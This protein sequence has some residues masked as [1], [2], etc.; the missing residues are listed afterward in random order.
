M[1]GWGYKHKPLHSIWFPLSR[2]SENHILIP[3]GI[4]PVHLRRHPDHSRPSISRLIHRPPPPPPNNLP[5]SFSSPSRQHHVLVGIHVPPLCVR[6]ADPAEHP[7]LHRDD[8]GDHW[9][10]HHYH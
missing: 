7:C 3:G 2:E 1:G 10:R 6:A 5:A 4:S 8:R 9:R